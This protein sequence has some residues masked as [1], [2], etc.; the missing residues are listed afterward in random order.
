MEF[1]YASQGGNRK[2]KLYTSDFV[3][4][5]DY[6]ESMRSVNVGRDL[7]AALDLMA[8]RGARNGT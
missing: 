6:R 1:Y 2:Q 7:G 8:A 5:A 3:M 4:Y